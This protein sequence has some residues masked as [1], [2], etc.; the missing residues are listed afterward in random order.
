MH[1]FSKNKQIIQKTKKLNANL[2]AHIN[3]QANKNNN[4]YKEKK[5]VTMNCGAKTCDILKKKFFQEKS[6]NSNFMKL[7]WVI[8]KL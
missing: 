3:K 2:K 7:G 8:K 6:R 4:K 1:F 5:I